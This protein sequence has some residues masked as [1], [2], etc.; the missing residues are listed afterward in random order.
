V[1]V[2]VKAHLQKRE[3]IGKLMSAPDMP[4][5]QIGR[6][7]ADGRPY[8]DLDQ[9]TYIIGLI[10]LNEALDFLFG[11]ELHEGDDMLR[12]G[13]KVVSYMKYKADQ[14]SKQYGLSFK[15]EESPAESASRRLAKVDMRQFPEAIEVIRGNV[16]ED[17]HYYT[18]SIHLRADAP[19]DL[20]TRIRLQAKFHSL[21]E[22]G[23]IIHAFV[24]EERPAPESILNLVE[25]IFRQTQA[26]QFTVSPEFT[27]CNVCRKN[28]RG[29][30]HKCSGCGV[31]DVPGVT[32]IEDELE[33]SRAKAVDESTV[34][35]LA[36]VHRAKTPS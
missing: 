17:E 16:D 20:V 5:W 9:C 6:L 23:A 36:R 13:L 24:G 30:V 29:L 27:V 33:K 10:G 28:T 31:E 14:A 7:G 18:N 22:S 15:L 21:I 8:V 35:E 25:K 3:F 4:L 1:D 32:R 12:E 11:R 2:S 26:A 34:A 19:V